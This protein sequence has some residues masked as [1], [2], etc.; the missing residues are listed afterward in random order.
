MAK[1]FTD[2]DMWSEDW[3]MVLPKDYKLFWY[4]LKDKC[5]HAG[6]WRC[7]FVIFNKLYDCNISKKKTLEFF[8][9]DKERIYI[10]DES[11]WLILDFF[12]F[13]YGSVLNLNNNMH[14]SVMAI[15]N[16]LGINIKNI[17]GLIEVKETSKRGLKEV[18]VRPKDKDKDIVKEKDI[19][20]SNNLKKKINKKEIP[21]SLD[22]ITDKYFKR[23]VQKWINHREKIKEQVKT[24]EQVNLIYKK[25][26]KLSSN[27]IDVATE[28]INN[29]IE[30]GYQG[31]FALDK[32]Q[33]NPR[34]SIR[35]KNYKTPIKYPAGKVID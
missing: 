8:N 2:T 6:V 28:I 32:K 21:I 34:Q 27:N 31:L 19:L 14:K 18:L 30:A 7:N 25:I 1:R 23:I 11:K 5:N 4:Y 35:S 24:Q 12:N 33:N 17:R 3:F 15:Y 13:Q 22:F 16:S 29:S 9:L 10:I 20:K 26:I